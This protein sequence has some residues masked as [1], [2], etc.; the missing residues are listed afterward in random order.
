LLFRF[1]GSPKPFDGYQ[2]GLSLYSAF[3]APR[4]TDPYGAEE[5]DP[6]AGEGEECCKPRSEEDCCAAAKAAGLA[7]TSWGGVIC[8]DGRKVSCY[9]TD[10]TWIDGNEKAKTI[11]NKCIKEH[12]DVHHSHIPDCSSDCPSLTRPPWK[13]GQDPNEGECVGYA[14]EIACLNRSKNECGDD[15]TCKSWIDHMINDRTRQRESFCNAGAE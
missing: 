4:N 6:S 7:G 14:A 1:G 12:E 11:I 5:T 2:D 8:C 15:N 9:W 10:G 3:F 13:E